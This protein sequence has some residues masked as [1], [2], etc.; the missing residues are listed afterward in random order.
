MSAGTGK[1]VNIYE[2]AKLAEMEDWYLSIYTLLSFAAH[3]KVSDLNCHVVV[4]VD[5]E[6]LE[7]QNE[8]VT[9]GQASVWAWVVE[10]QLAAMRS[11]A[12]LF[13]LEAHELEALSKRLVD[14]PEQSDEA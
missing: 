6:P 12:A 8:P 4:G 9:S 3:S 1:P 10:V 7:F 5:G 13:S 2:L 11:V 14:L